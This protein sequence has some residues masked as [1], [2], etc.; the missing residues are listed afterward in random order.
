VGGF[1]AHSIVW[2]QL[3]N[4]WR[5]L[6]D[7]YGIHVFHI[8]D[9]E[10]GYGEFKGW[11]PERRREMIQEAIHVLTTFRELNGFSAA[12]LVDDFNALITPAVKAVVGDH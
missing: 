6:L 2:F 8:A 10:S 11:P 9:C 12:L 1:A 3:E 5:R 4:I 7:N